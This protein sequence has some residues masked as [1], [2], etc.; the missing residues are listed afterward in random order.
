MVSKRTA[1]R[2]P[3]EE[4][5][6]SPLPL[7]IIAVLVAILVGAGYFV[8]ERAYSD[9]EGGSSSIDYVDDGGGDAGGAPAFVLVT[10]EG[11]RIDSRSLK[12]KVIVLD[13]MATWCAP[14]SY[15]VDELKDVRARYSTEDVV[16]ISVDIDPNES[17]SQLKEYKDSKGANWDFCM[18][19]EDFRDNYPADAIPTLY[20]L[21]RDFD[22]YK[23]YRGAKSSEE[24]SS[25]IDSIL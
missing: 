9:E 11:K 3:R 6:P 5:K 2:S 20:I 19:T 21:D 1:M 16:I 14:C 13:L 10:T 8:S 24:L 7:I 15:Q 25:T 12:G 4:E 18:A 22:I 17:A 23:V